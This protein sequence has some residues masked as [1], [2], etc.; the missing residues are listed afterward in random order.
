M[1][2]KLIMFFLITITVAKSFATVTNSR[3]FNPNHRNSSTSSFPTDDHDH[4]PTNDPNCGTKAGGENCAAG[5]CCSMHGYCGKSPLY[6]DKGCQPK[7]GICKTGGG[8]HYPP[9]PPKMNKSPPPPP[10]SCP[11]SSK[12]RTTNSDD[13]ESVDSPY[14]KPQCGTQGG[15]KRCDNQLCCSFFGYCGSTKKYC[16]SG[17]QKGYG[18]CHG[19]GGSPPPPPPCTCD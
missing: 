15:K 8:G 1:T 5:F 13:L 12:E 4:D 10:C 3:S 19:S 7:Y 16:G 6:C 18:L 11:P 17:C 2:M 9:P 14:N